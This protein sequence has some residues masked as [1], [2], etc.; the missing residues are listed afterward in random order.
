MRIQPR[1]NFFTKHTER[2]KMS[3]ATRRRSAFSPSTGEQSTWRRPRRSYG[4]A[5]RRSTLST[6]GLVK[7]SMGRSE[8]KRGRNIQKMVRVVSTCSSA[9]TTE[10]SL[11]CMST[12]TRL[13]G[14]RGTIRGQVHGAMDAVTPSCTFHT[15]L[16][17]QG[18][19]LLPRR[20]RKI[21]SWAAL[22][23]KIRP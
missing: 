16:V 15:A 11:Q 2:R 18:S 6:L 7:L 5:R 23:P 1:A 22:H 20:A 21:Y 10:P 4:W 14:G 17:R 19:R 13:C 8:R 9:L 12:I 3:S